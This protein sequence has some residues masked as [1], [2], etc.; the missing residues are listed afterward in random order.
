MPNHLL[1]VISPYFDLLESTLTIYRNALVNDNYIPS[2]CKL[3]S[4]SR[5]PT[6]ALPTKNINT[7]VS[8]P[9]RAWSKWWDECMCGYRE[10]LVWF[11]FLYKIYIYVCL[12]IWGKLSWFVELLRFELTCIC[13]PKRIKLRSNDVIFSLI[14]KLDGKPF[15]TTIKSHAGNFLEAAATSQF[16]HCNCWV[17]CKLNTSV[18]TYVCLCGVCEFIFR[19]IIRISL[20]HSLT[21]FPQTITHKNSACVR[22]R[23]VHV[24]VHVQ[25]EVKHE[26]K[27]D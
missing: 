17:C 7:K 9:V 23:W 19:W 26:C 2:C 20:A 5:L 10:I 6:T 14:K 15:W 1:F 16:T 27:V 24:C 13:R 18:C 21:C 12:L 22:M 3:F 8:E 11:R 25:F 4:V